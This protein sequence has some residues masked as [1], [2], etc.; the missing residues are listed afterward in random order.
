[1]VNVVPREVPRPKPSGP[2]APR[3]LALGPVV[4]GIGRSRPAQ[5]NIGRG[6]PRPKHNSKNLNFF[7]KILANNTK[8]NTFNTRIHLV[9]PRRLD[10]HP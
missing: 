3:V 7:F 5:N 10:G 6:W 2:A 8:K 1:M 9:R 4:N